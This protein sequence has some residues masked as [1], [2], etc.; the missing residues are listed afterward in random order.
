MHIIENLLL[1]L[2]ADGHML[3][4]FNFGVAKELNSILNSKNDEVTSKDTK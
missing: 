3:N 1:R 4:L 2:T